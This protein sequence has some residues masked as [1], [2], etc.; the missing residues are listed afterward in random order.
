MCH[1]LKENGRT[2]AQAFG[3]QMFNVYWA[4][5]TNEALDFKVSSKSVSMSAGPYFPASAQLR[6]EALS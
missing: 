4:S 6:S 3:F 5:D 1:L 2:P